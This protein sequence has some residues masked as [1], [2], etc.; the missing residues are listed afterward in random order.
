MDNIFE[1]AMQME[2]DGRE[3]YLKGA[4]QTTNAGLKKIFKQ[5]ADEEHRHYHVFKRLAEGEVTDVAEETKT[6]KAGLTLTKSLFRE[7]AE[8]GKTTLPG[9]AEREVWNEARVIEEKSVQMYAEEAG[10]QSDAKRKALLNQ[11]ADEERTH[12]HLIDNILAFLSDPSGFQESQ[13]YRNFM[14][15]EGH[16]KGG[17]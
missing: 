3:F 12:V 11:L 9:D 6:S 10:R 4:E 14:S 1:F 7:M 13:N 16:D 2:L 8:Q 17:W 5:L 15:W